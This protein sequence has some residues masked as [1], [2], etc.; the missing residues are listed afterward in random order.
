MLERENAKLREAIGVL[1]SML[2]GVIGPRR[3]TDP[4]P[5]AWDIL[6]AARNALAQSERK[7]A[8]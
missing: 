8:K 4:N 3:A 7:G 6:D 2:D 5:E 1:V